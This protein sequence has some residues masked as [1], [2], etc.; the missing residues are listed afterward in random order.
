MMEW[1]LLKENRRLRV[2]AGLETAEDRR[3]MALQNDEDEDEEENE[4]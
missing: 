1:F 2:L 3:L 4:D